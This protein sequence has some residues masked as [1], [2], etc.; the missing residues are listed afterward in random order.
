MAYEVLDEPAPAGRY[1]VLPA[2]TGRNVAADAGNAVGTGYFRGL[3]RLAGMPVDV[4][5][6]V[7]DLGKAALGV[8]YIAATGRSP[9][10]WLELVDRANVVGSGDNLVKNLS[11]TRAGNFMVNPAN[12]AFEGGYAQAIGGGLNGV[13]R[14]NTVLQA[15]NQAAS[16]VAGTT[17]GKATFDATGSAPL[18]IAAGMSPTALQSGAIDLSQRAI[19]GGEEGRRA[20]AQRVQD[21]KNA[22]VDNPTMGLASG[23]RLIGGVE[24]LLQS[25]PG[26][27]GVMRRSRD[28]AVAGL[29]GKTS[30]AAQ[31]ASPQRG[32]L[33]AGTSIQA[34][35]KSFR[36][37]FKTKQGALYDKMDAFIPGQTP[38][39]VA[40]TKRALSILNAD[41][42]GAPELSKQFKNARIVSIEEAMKAD[43]AGAPQGL[44]V[45]TVGGGGLMNGPVTRSQGLLT[46]PGSSTD[47]LPFQAVKQ[48][49]TLVGN[50]IADSGLMPSVP[51][52]KWNSLYGALSDD[53]QKTANA[54]GTQ[55]TKAFNRASNF[56]RSGV[57]RLDRVAPFAD[58]VAPEQAYTAMVQATKENVS[59]LRAVKKTLPEGARGSVAGTVIERLGKGT[60]GVQNESGSVWSPETFLTNWNKMKPEARTEL[61]SGFKDSA[62]VMADV[63]AVAKAA[64]MMRENSKMWANPSGTGANLAARGLLG[65]VGAGGAGAAAGLLNPLVPVGAGLAMFGANGMARG[66]TSAKA[67][68]SATKNNY[69]DPRML[70]SQVNSL[71]GSGLLNYQAQN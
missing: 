1:E 58:K 45:Q 15:T 11:K 5:A 41:I 23:N 16:S 65:A 13:I 31:A 30:G 56:S 67:V 32:A 69:I 39:N 66:L 51:R 47:S 40:G 28:A 71:I 63:S 22:G 33:E 37:D 60:N 21:L 26:A 18:A 7:M 10:S 54:S 68:E 25:T 36:D 24:N 9:P 17:L 64:A 34:G 8:P 70:N 2:P 53:M 57:D 49:R 29:E 38:T 61:F 19:R 55:A 42:P 59:T 46:T 48:T 44:L 4:V 50:E 6:N 43:T 52:S 3:T 27:I 14:P 20:M 12:P 35:I 62:K